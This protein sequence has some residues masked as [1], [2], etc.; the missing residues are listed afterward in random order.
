MRKIGR[1]LAA[2]LAG[3]LAAFAPAAAAQAD[4]NVKP[5]PRAELTGSAAC[6][7]DGWKAS[8]VLRN[9]GQ[10]SFIEIVKV[11]GALT[12]LDAGAVAPGG[13][14]TGSVVLSKEARWTGLE[15][16]YR[17]VEPSP[18]PSAPDGSA[19]PP[20]EV[21]PSGGPEDGDDGQGVSTTRMTGTHPPKTH[22]V[23]TH[24]KR[25][26]CPWTPPTSGPSTPP[27]DNP[28]TP[29]TSPPSDD[30]TSPPSQDPD[31][32]EEP[33]SP[34]DDDPSLPPIE[35][36]GSKLP[37]TG[38]PVVGLAV[39]GGLVLLAGAAVLLVLHRRRQRFEA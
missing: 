36:V 29:P 35:E 1:G 20:G 8:F 9:N 28:S 23:K 19:T 27:S 6:T 15:V 17:W 11:S 16:Q 12:A 18:S 4:L 31:P 7:A 38:A 39:T 14:A 33:T 25:C 10:R 37:L 26:A 24:V 5:A 3:A 2:L 34:P 13:T 32:S 21:P 22:T 30:P